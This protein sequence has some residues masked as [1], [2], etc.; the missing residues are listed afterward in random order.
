MAI[1][2]AHQGSQQTVTEH[3]GT[4]MGIN[5]LMTA[6]GKVQDVPVCAQQCMYAIMLPANGE[7]GSIPAVHSC[8]GCL[9]Q[10]Q[11]TVC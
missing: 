11:G 10:Y 4:V 9:V 3:T 8:I 7:A 2:E 6:T 5:H 1:L